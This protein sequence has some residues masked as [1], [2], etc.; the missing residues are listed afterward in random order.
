MQLLRSPLLALAASAAVAQAQEYF[1][2]RNAF[3]LFREKAR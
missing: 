3:N 2:V 1:S